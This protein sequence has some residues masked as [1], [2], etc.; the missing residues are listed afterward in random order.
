MGVDEAERETTT[1]GRES[2]VNSS[3][4]ARGRADADA[5]ARPDAAEG[6]R[7][8]AAGRADGN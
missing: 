1:A 2:S 7:A 5:R 8:V 3:T 6:W 4:A